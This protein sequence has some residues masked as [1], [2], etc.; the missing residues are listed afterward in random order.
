MYYLTI[1][2]TNC[3]VH[4]PKVDYA[5]PGP[6]RNLMETGSGIVDVNNP[7]WDRTINISLRSSIGP[8]GNFRGGLSIHSNSRHDCSTPLRSI[9]ETDLTSPED[10]LAHP[11][12]TEDFQIPTIRYHNTWMYRH[13]TAPA[14]PY[15]TSQ[16]TLRQCRIN[17]AVRPRSYATPRSRA[18]NESPSSHLLSQVSS[19][20]PTLRIPS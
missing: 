10:M 19:S 6:A 12:M 8:G 3:V 16:P 13:E 9:T 11:E 1:F 18:Q 20:R 15:P 5:R 17:A 7:L 2:Q 4:S 14:A